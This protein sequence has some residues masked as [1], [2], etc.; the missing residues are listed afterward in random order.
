MQLA[1]LGGARGAWIYA[2][3]HDDHHLT[4]RQFCLCLQHRFCKPPAGREPPHPCQHR[5][6]TRTCNTPLGPGHTATSCPIGGHT[7]IKHNRLRDVLQAW[8]QQQGGT[9]KPDQRI[10]ECDYYDS[11]GNLVEAWLDLV[12][13]PEGGSV[14]H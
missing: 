9:A 12:V 7:T 8:V 4:R 14:S 13:E 5:N 1:V 10:G 2:S 11:G 6:G 3:E